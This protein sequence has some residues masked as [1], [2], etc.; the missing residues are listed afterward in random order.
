MICEPALFSG[1]KAQILQIVFVFFRERGEEIAL[2]LTFLHST[3]AEVFPYYCLSLT[4]LAI[5][6]EKRVV[7]VGLKVKNVRSGFRFTLMKIHMYLYES[8]NRKPLTAR[9]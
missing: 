8:V 9:N 2:I 1:K 6:R 5:F 7:K 4:I 3:I